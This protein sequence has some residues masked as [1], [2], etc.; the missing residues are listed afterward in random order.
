MGGYLVSVLSQL[1]SHEGSKV[2]PILPLKRQSPCLT[3]GAIRVNIDCISRQPTLQKAL[4]GSE[5]RW[6]S[7]QGPGFIGAFSKPHSQ[8]HK[9][10]LRCCFCFYLCVM[11]FFR[12]LEGFA[13]LGNGCQEG[14]SQEGIETSLCLLLSSDS[15][16]GFGDIFLSRQPFCSF[17]EGKDSIHWKSV[18]GHGFQPKNNRRKNITSLT[19]LSVKT[20]QPSSNND[21]KFSTLL[22][23][24][25]IVCP[26][27]P[28]VFNWIHIHISAHYHGKIRCPQHL[29]YWQ[30]LRMHEAGW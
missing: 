3:D 25:Y 1:S 27:S 6:C 13:C 8:H 21:T 11:F 30:K 16:G 14:R 20:Q 5:S 7:L 18:A 24:I 4:N 28:T 23:Y 9:V 10:F 19:C 29:P 22:E 12:G 15:Y 2:N 26:L 17:T